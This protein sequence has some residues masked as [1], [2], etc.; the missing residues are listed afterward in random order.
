MDPIALYYPYIHIRDD[1]W[2]K[3]SALYWPKMG[4]LCPPGFPVRDS[5]TA[6]VLHD[7][8]GWLIDV[9]P[10]PWAGRVVGGPFLDLILTHASELRNRFGLNRIDDWKPLAPGIYQDLDRYY[11]S[12][13]PSELRQAFDERLSYV[14][15]S[16]VDYNLVRAAV[17]AGLVTTLDHGTWVGMHPEL[18]S[19]Y[20]CALTEQIAAGDR[21]HP[22][23][24]QMLP[25]SALSGWTMDRLAQAL[26]NEPLDSTDESHAQQDLAD[27]FA[28]LAFETVVPAHLDT[29]PIEKIV[30][31]RSRFG[32]ELDAFRNYVTEQAQRLSELHDIR[33]LP[34]FQEYLRTEVQHAVSTQLAQLR[35]QLRSIGLES[36]RAMVNVKSVALPPL[37]GMAAE[38]IG[39]SPAI[40]GPAA[41]AACVVTAPAQWRGHR[42]T[43]IQESPVGYLFRIDQ[44]L[45]PA[46]LIDR[47]RRTWPR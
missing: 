10:P 35:E 37:V 25:H 4:R 12:P 33:D 11:R 29:V 8:I 21:L 14:H 27:A 5:R 28:L 41:L 22:V 45:N 24:D 17:E 9:P 13:R 18:A 42:R 7:E 1:A 16:K 40:T 43:T 32:T 15:I 36:A 2:L 20:T 26:V 38:T 34:V 19:V 46:K 31:V 3:Y 47:L 44:E 39:L 6:R 23:T 30:E